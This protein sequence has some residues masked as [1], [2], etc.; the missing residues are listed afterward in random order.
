[1]AITSDVSQPGQADLAVNEAVRYLGG[2]DGLAVI[3]GAMGQR[4]PFH[5]AGDDVWAGTFAR[6]LLPVVRSC[7][8]ALPHLV[9]SGSGAIVTVAAYSMRAP[10]SDMA[11]Y[12]AMKAAVATLTKSMAKSYGRQGVR[13]NCVAPGVLVGPKADDLVERYGVPAD[14]AHYLHVAT[15]YGM[16]VALERAGRPEEVADLIAFLLSERAGYVT[17]ALI[18]IDGGTDF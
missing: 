8:A 12:A 15:N 13:A 3:A 2:L 17:G 4:G 9:A 18:N 5:E 16:N 1:L 6:I 10:H 14:K 11:D 7:R